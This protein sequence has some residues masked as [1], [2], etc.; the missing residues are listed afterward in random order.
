MEI[1]LDDDTILMLA[2][3]AHKKDITINKY[4]EEIL[5]YSIDKYKSTGTL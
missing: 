4:I 2:K 5:Q 3:A 1:D